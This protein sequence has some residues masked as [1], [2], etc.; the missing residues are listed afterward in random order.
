MD[1]QQSQTYKN[2]QNAY[3]EL[4][5]S[6]TK[7]NIFSIRAEKEVYI[8]IENIFSVASRNERFISE[9]VRSLL[10][11]GIPSTYQNLVEARDEGSSNS[12]LFRQY[13][14]MAGD[15]GYND[16]SS[17]F[18]GIA[19]IMLNHTAS[20]QNV[21]DDIN[22]NQL[23]CKENRVLWVCLGCGNILAGECA[24]SVCPICGYPQ[25]YYQIYLQ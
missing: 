21:I 2:L 17:L 5:Q 20:F 4:L 12:E 18:S 11:G 10:L 16:I 1:F 6:C 19:N 22:N 3:A 23:F 15:E 8:G 7:Y 24:P 13:A 9:K 14:R 25:G